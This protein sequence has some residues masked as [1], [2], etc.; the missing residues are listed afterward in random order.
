MTDLFFKGGILFMSIL[1]VL[2]SLILGLVIVVIYHIKQGYTDTKRFSLLVS[3][4]K[5]LGILAFV[6]G[7]LAQLI[8]LFSA[9][10]ALGLGEVEANIE[11]ITSGLKVSLI[12]LGYGVLIGLLAFTVVSVVKIKT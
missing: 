4:L 2:F 12:P 1:S 8:S 11:V 9:F 10:K 7:I 6:F 3:W 5:E